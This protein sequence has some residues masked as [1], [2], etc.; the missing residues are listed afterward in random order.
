MRTIYDEFAHIWPVNRHDVIKS[1]FKNVRCLRLPE[2][3]A[4]LATAKKRSTVIVIDQDDERLNPV[5]YLLMG[6]EHVL[7]SQRDD[8]PSELFA[9]CLMKTRPTN[10]SENPLHF[11]FNGFSPASDEDLHKNFTRSLK[12]S[13]QK[14]QAIQDLDTFLGQDPKLQSIRPLCLESSDE[15]L[16]N[17]IYNAPVS[18]MGERTHKNTPREVTVTLEREVKLFACY[19]D[20]KIVVGCEDLYGSIDRE[21]VLTRVAAI[22]NKKTFSPLESGAGAG[23]GLKMMISNSA[24]FYIY[25]ESRRRTLIACGFLLRGQKS[26][27]SPRKHLHLSIY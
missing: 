19:S 9:A 4:L 13:I 3:L 12:S 6:F 22:Y 16:S 17:A 1:L 5:N 20:K 8:F 15:M 11:F 23:L 18:A 10:F 26:N 27:Q 14:A 24:N 25:C 2:D 21:E 7:N